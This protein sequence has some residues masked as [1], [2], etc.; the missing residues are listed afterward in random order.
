MEQVLK[1]FYTYHWPPSYIDS[2]LSLPK[3][4]ARIAVVEDWKSE[5]AF[6]SRMMRCE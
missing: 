1:Y 4:S 5:R 6:S 3:G 2:W